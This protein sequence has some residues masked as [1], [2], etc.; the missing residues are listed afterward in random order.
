MSTKAIR[1]LARLCR[2]EGFTPE[3]IAMGEAALAE[4][5]AI[6]KAAREWQGQT[7]AE[8]LRGDKAAPLWALLDAIAKEANK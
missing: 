2:D 5:E 1:R 3:I 8:T 6:R 7:V 4:L